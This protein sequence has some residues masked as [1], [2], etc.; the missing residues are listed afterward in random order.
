MSYAKDRAKA[1]AKQALQEWHNNFLT[2]AHASRNEEISLVGAG[3][4]IPDEGRIYGERHRAMFEDYSTQKREAAVKALSD[5]A[6]ELDEKITKAP[7]DEALRAMQAFAL[8]KNPGKSAPAD[9]REAYAQRVDQM[10]NQYGSN[11]MVYDALQQMA[12]EAGIY[13]FNPH[14]L[15]AERQQLDNA[16]RSIER[17]VNLMSAD[18]GYADGWHFDLMEQAIDNL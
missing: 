3:G 7:D 11:V 15:H 13:N 1:A 6:R 4:R 2:T 12:E 5:Y 14:A 18:G 16:I 9:A 17:H 10:M 8:L